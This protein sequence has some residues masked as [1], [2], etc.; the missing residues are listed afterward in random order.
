MGPPLAAG[1]AAIAAA[2]ALLTA[3]YVAT[4]RG[5]VFT[6]RIA[7]LVCA[8][9]LFS[10]AVFVVVGLTLLPTVLV[11]G[12][13]LFGWGAIHLGIVAVTL[14]RMSRTGA[15]PGTPDRPAPSL[16]GPLGDHMMAAYGLLAVGPLVV[17]IGLFLAFAQ[18]RS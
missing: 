17:L 12:L 3:R 13:V 9:M 18:G 8:P 14:A 2:L 1:I 7:W 5:T 6:D 16:T 15:D 4:R 10:G 11:A